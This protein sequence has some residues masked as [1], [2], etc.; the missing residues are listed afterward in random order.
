MNTDD[1]DPNAPRSL[2]LT[3]SDHGD[4]WLVEVFRNRISPEDDDVCSMLAEL[5][6]VVERMHTEAHVHQELAERRN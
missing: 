4:T 2:T 1:D 5:G 3:I 6:R